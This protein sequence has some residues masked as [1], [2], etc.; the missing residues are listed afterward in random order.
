M[1][2][3]GSAVNLGRGSRIAP[4]S[5]GA[6]KRYHGYAFDLAEMRAEP[7]GPLHPTARRGFRPSNATQSFNVQIL[8]TQVGSFQ[9]PRST[10]WTGS[11]PLAEP[12][13]HHLDR[14]LQV[15]AGVSQAKEP[16]LELRWRE[17]NTGTQTMM[18]KG[19]KR[20]QVG[21]PGVGQVADRG[22][23]EVETEHGT[24]AMKR[25]ISAGLN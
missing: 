21:P 20:S 9:E 15:R 18:K 23:A 24:N 19:P 8:R 22:F 13:F 4:D 7:L 3:A 17:I 5:F 10:K 11:A 12:A 2:N 16:G 14:P 25:V 6:L 1:K